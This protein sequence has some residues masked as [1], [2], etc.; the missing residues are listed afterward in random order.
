[1]S[2][3][4]HP[5]SRSSLF[6]VSDRPWLSLLF[7]AAMA[8][9][10]LWCSGHDEQRCVQLVL[11]AIFAGPV[12]AGRSAAKAIAGMRPV[13]RLCL[14]AF[15]TLG[16]ISASMTFSLRHAAYEWSILLLLLLAAALL[17][18]ELARSGK[19]GLQA[20]LYC[21]GVACL[22]YS[23]RVVLMYA[24]ALTSGIHIDM[25]MLAVGFSNARFLNHTQTALLPLVVL[26]CMHAPKRTVMRRVWFVLAAFWW[27]LLFVSEARAT[28]LAF[29][30]AGLAV[31]VLRRS[32]A[33]TLLQMMALT[34]LAGVVVYV[35][36]FILLPMLAGQGAIGMPSN[37]VARTAAD[38]SSGR[39]LLWTLALQLIAT[40]PWLGVG[41]QHFAHEGAKLYI[42]AHPHD[43]LLQ[44]GAEWGLPALLCLLV[45]AISG[46][47]ALAG[48]GKRIEEG[49]VHN[50]Q[51]LAALLTACAAIFVD[52]LFSGVLV[53]PQSQLAIALVIGCAGGWLHS[54]DAG[55]VQ[56]APSPAT[57]SVT[58]VLA[59]VALCTLAWSIA[60]DFLRHAKG[61]V[62]TPTERA[63]ND[64]AH[65]PRLWEAG[66]F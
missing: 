33:R 32:H 4:A 9:V 13:A 41:P 23:L 21:M 18:A 53:M 55:M 7:I 20:V 24:A 63:I 1:M 45:A 61:E 60:P 42:G 62:L 8:V 64:K 30:A 57:R 66:Y 46:I 2:S 49:D 31:L 5:A 43:W 36:G 39:T 34:A 38:P 19:A 17:A 56:P 47:R 54:L 3:S 40:H 59:A 52:G 28:I 22:L 11:L 15:F 26:L 35:F 12:I 48:S 58:A 37:V 29:G 10:F 44:I 65:W 14:A 51:I 25:H 27:A 6:F 16:A 50:Q